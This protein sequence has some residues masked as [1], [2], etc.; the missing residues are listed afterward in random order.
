M[1]SDWYDWQQDSLLLRLYVQPKSS[2]DEYVAP[3]G[4]NSYKVKI[5]APPIEGKANR[6][7]CRFV[8]NSFGVP[9]SHV[10]IISG[11]NSR[12]KRLKIKNPTT[13][14]IAITKASQQ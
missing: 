14:P 13:L 1:P 10:S 5:T 4:D 9:V 2:K 6:H 7:L 8:A 3:H 11:Q 12:H